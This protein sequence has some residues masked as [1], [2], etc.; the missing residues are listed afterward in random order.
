MMIFF[1]GVNDIIRQAIFLA[2]MLECSGWYPI[3]AKAAVIRSHPNCLIP[4]VNFQGINEVGRYTVGIAL[5]M[6]IMHK[7]VFKRY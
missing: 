4:I 3:G 1:N 5:I 7:L 2:V 6:L